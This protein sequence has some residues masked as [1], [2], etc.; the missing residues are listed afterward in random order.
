M[1]IRDSL[2]ASGPINDLSLQ[3]AVQ[4]PHLNGEPASV[5][6][7][8]HLNIAS[9]ELGLQQAQA[10]YHGQTLRL[11]APARLSYADGLAINK[12]RLGVQRAVISVDGR[13]A[14][15]LDLRASVHQL[16]AALVSAFVPDVLAAGS[17]DADAQLAGC[18]LYTSRCV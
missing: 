8:A 2:T 13:V 16:D 14:P 6:A 11:L 10:H 3:V 15:A 1:C 5:D 4:S 17:L 7:A 12:L 9:H 18:L